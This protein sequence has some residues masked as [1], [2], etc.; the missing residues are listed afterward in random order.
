MEKKLINKGFRKRGGISIIIIT[1]VLVLLVL[2]S[3][4]SLKSL[5]NSN[6]NASK[7]ISTQIENVT[8]P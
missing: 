7:K 4:P 8:K 3:L 1:I 6:A 2:V 5:V